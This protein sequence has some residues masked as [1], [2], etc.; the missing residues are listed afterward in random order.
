[1]YN[2]QKKV[3]RLRR[4]L[5]RRT[6][7]RED[8]TPSPDQDLSTGSDRSYRPQSRTS[9]NRSHRHLIV[10]LDEYTIIE[11]LELHQ[12]EARGMMP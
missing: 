7:I 10:L 5:R 6:Q 4:S 2:L 11:S 9:P 8:R 12:G 3:E 1:M